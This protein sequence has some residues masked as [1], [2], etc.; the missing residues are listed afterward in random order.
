MFLTYDHCTYERMIKDPSCGDVGDA[1]PP[2]T[3]SHITEHSQQGLEEGPISPRLED[4]IEILADEGTRRP[5][6][7]DAKKEIK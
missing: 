6:E 7:Q 3:I 1:C 5:P 4:D 2:V